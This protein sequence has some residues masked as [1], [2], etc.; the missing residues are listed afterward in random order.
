MI[1]NVGDTWKY[2]PD[3]HRIAGYLGLDSQARQNYRV[4]QKVSYLMNMAS[5]KAKSSEV[6][7]QMHQLNKFKK[8]LGTN[9]QGE[10]LINTMYQYARL[11]QDRQVLSD[12]RAVEKKEQEE[13]PDKKEEDKESNLSIQPQKKDDISR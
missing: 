3:Y 7:D 10:T 13:K 12:K 2:D 9:S 5:R 11:E 4:Y 6:V 8:S 1:D